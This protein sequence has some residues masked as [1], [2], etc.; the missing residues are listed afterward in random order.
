MQDAHCGAPPHRVPCLLDA[1]RS[2]TRLTP[3][4]LV[5]IPMLMAED[6]SGNHDLGNTAG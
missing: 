2:Q 5:I 4:A 1:L 6:H 3:L